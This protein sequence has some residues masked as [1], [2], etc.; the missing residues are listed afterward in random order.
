[1]NTGKIQGRS[2]PKF[3]TFHPKKYT[4]VHT[5]KRG[6][7]DYFR[8]MSNQ[9]KGVQKTHSNR[10][11]FLVLRLSKRSG[12]VKGVGKWLQNFFNPNL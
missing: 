2:S 1:M 4:K 12:G 6:F 3:H 8:Q 11:T 5:T 9:Y 7:T 10:D